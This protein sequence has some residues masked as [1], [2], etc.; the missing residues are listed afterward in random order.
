M[1]VFELLRI[2]VSFEML[3]HNVFLS[4]FG[5]CIKEDFVDIETCFLWVGQFGKFA[6]FYAQIHFFYEVLAA[7]LQWH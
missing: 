4:F 2:H 3:P 6:A 5:G 1:N 7:T